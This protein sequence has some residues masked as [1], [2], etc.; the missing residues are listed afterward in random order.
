MSKCSHLVAVCNVD[1]SPNAADHIQSGVAK[2]ERFAAVCNVDTRPTSAN[3]I[4]SVAK[5]EQVVSVCCGLQRRHV[6]NRD[7][8]W[9]TSSTRFLWFAV[10]CTVGIWS[11]CIGLMRRFCAS[12]KATRLHI[13]L[14]DCG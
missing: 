6:A 13:C 14:F 1:T 11:W 10:L 4:P 9:P 12:A 7:Q 5:F 3:C 2:F 8:L